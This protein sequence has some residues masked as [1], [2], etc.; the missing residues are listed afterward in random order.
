MWLAEANEPIPQA[1]L[2]SLAMWLVKAN[3]AAPWFSLYLGVWLVDSSTLRC[4]S[5]DSYTL[6]CGALCLGMWIVDSSTLLCYWVDF[7]P[8]KVT[9]WRKWCCT[10][11]D[12]RI[13]AP[14]DVVGCTL[15]PCDVIGW[16][17]W[18]R[19]ADQLI[20]GFLHLAMWLVDHFYLEMWLVDGNGVVHPSNLIGGFLHLAMWLGGLQTLRCDW[21]MGIELYIRPIWLEDS[22]TLRCD[23][24]ASYTLLCGW[25]YSYTLR[26]DWLYSYTFQCDWLYSYTLQC[27][28]LRR[29]VPYRR[30][31]D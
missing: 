26:C 28:L 31:T 30:P 24:V 4:G 22:S 23:W 6:R 8:C 14:C 15:I 20:A 29:M 18:C 25:L 21:L 17:E 5:V 13:L 16:G 10:V 11:C 19:T 7:I 3:G 1:F 2:S 27:D 9:F 12:W